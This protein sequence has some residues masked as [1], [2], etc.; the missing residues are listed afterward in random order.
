MYSVYQ[1]KTSREFQ[2]VSAISE[3]RTFVPGSATAFPERHP[4]PCSYMLFTHRK[5]CHKCAQLQ[6]GEDQAVDCCNHP[7][8][9][10][11]VHG[12]T[13]LSEWVEL[14]PTSSLL[15][16]PVIFDWNATIKFL[17]T[18]PS[19]WPSIHYADPPFE[20]KLQLSFPL[21]DPRGIVSSGN[22]QQER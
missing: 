1:N 20:S 10:G 8:L 5:R 11:L 7:T 3:V 16:V 19:W 13:T 17:F 14:C 4:L 12:A 15:L 2:T 22:G 9:A 6:E 21:L 18:S